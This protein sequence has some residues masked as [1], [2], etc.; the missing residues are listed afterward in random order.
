MGTRGHGAGRWGWGGLEARP[1]LRCRWYLHSKMS[2]VWA[3]QPPAS[4]CQRVNPPLSPPLAAGA[5][6]HRVALHVWWLEAEGLGRSRRKRA[7]AGRLGDFVAADRQ[8]SGCQQ[9]LPPCPRAQSRPRPC[10]PRV[11]S[12]PKTSTSEATCPSP[13]YTPARNPPQPSG[14]RLRLIP[15]LRLR[16][17][18]HPQKAE[19]DKY[20]V[21]PILLGFLCFVVFGSGMAALAIRHPSPA[22]MGLTHLAGRCPPP[23]SPAVVFQMLQ[24]IQYGAPP[25]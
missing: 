9:I 15:D 16:V 20:P 23:L 14:H 17:V 24:Q 25:Q 7:G 21:G 1:T 22:H 18:V 8:P 10:V 12:T 11:R 6:A 19:G 4:S 2:L 5:A 13:W 3:V